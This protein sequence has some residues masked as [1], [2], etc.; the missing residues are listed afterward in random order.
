MPYFTQSSE[1]HFEFDAFTVPIY[2]QEHCVKG[3]LNNLPQVTQQEKERSQV[4]T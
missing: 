1:Q 4:Q 2:K 3:E